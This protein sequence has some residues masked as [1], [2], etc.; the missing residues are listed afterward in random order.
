M[1]YLLN[2]KVYDTEKAEEILKRLG[3]TFHNYNLRKRERGDWIGGHNQ[4][5]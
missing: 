3:N 4:N 5:N 1:K 2:N